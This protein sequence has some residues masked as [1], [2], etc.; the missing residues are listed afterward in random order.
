M[1]VAALRMWFSISVYSPKREHFVAVF[2]V[3]TERKAHE[4]EIERLNKLYATLSGINKAVVRVKTREELFQEVCHTTAEHAGFKVVWVGW[5]D[6]ESHEVMPVARSGDKQAYLDNIKVY[7]DDRPEGRGP[8]GICIREDRPSIFNDF[9]HSELS[10][11][12]QKA[13]V[14]H[15]LRAVAAFPIHCNKKVCGAFTVYDSEANVFQDKEVALLEEAA[16]DISFALD[17]LDREARKQ[18]AEASLHQSDERFRRAMEAT[19]DGLWEWNIETGQT[20]YSPGYLKMLGY[21]GNESL[22]TYTVWTDLIHPDDL[23]SVLSTKQDCIENRREIFQTEFRM[24]SKDG[25]WRWI[26][27]RGKAASRDAEGKARLVVGTHVDITERKQI[28][29]KIITAKE[30]WRTPLML[31]RN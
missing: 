15:E 20:Y 16:M 27:G 29:Q 8:V 31:S 19:S 26:L 10:A 23:A 6:L 1:F 17:N 13:L 24:R 22:D 4:R 12:W 14:A 18:A 25:T 7:A 9:Q 30:E 28:E 5:Q 11:S 2:E 3:I 21:V